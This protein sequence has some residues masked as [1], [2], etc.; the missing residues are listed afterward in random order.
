MGGGGGGK[1]S[2]SGSKPV[3]NS[4]QMWAAEMEK[5][6]EM[7]KQQYEAQRQ[8]YEDMRKEED[9]KRAA[10]QAKRDQELWNEKQLA[11]DKEALE[12]YTKSTQSYADQIGGGPSMSDSTTSAINK[13]IGDQSKSSAPAP[14]L[15]PF[16]TNIVKPANMIYQTTGS[17]LGGL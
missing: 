13:K 6:R 16:G 4:M 15:T 1:K 2:S 10:E 11:K 9:A 17:R 8:Q 3:D 7:Q 14:G 12:S 5:Q